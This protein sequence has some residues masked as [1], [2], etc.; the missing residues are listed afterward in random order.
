MAVYDEMLPYRTFLDKGS[1]MNTEVP[2]LR[3]T[4]PVWSGLRLEKEALVRTFVQG[5]RPGRVRLTPWPDGP[6]I[7][8]PAPPQGATYR[9]A[10]GLDHITVTPEPAP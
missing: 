4:G 9:L 1:I 10:R 2:G 7:T 6:S 3:D 8:L 5:D